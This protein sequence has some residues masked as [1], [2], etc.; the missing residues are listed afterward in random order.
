MEGAGRKKKQRK[1]SAGHL[2]AQRIMLIKLFAQRKSTGKS[3]ARFAG[4]E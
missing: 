2:S 3:S 4:K 1:R